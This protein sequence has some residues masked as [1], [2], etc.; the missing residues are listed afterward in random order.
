MIVADTNVLVYATFKDSEF[1]DQSIKIIEREDVVIPQIV[2]YEYIK[3]LAE[4]HPD[5]DFIRT[6]IE[7]LKDFK[8]I[9]EDIETI[10]NAINLLNETSLSL[11][12]INDFIILSLTLKIGGEL[13][14]FDNKLR[15]IAEK[16]SI[17]VIP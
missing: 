3:V 15:K 14:T 8:I 5:L 9:P 1:F 2:V 10:E 13:A 17:K 16:I 6:K 11:K 4:I 7:E 12:N